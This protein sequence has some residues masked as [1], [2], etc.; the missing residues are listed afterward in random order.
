MTIYLTQEFKNAISE[1]DDYEPVEEVDED[2]EY[3]SVDEIILFLESITDEEYEDD[4]DGDED[5]HYI[6]TE[7]ELDLDGDEDDY[8]ILTEE[9]DEE[10]DECI[11]DDDNNRFINALLDCVLAL[12]DENSR[13]YKEGFVEIELDEDEGEY[14]VMTEEQAA[15]HRKRLRER[16]ARNTR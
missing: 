1:S 2:S 15:N 5:E 4:E 8:Y 10:L 7:D 9:P 12:I 6:L 13:C 3:L 14:Y 11:E 16:L